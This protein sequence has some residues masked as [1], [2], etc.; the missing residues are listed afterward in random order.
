MKSAAEI[1][2]ELYQKRLEEEAKKKEIEEYWRKY[3][4]KKQKE[5]WEAIRKILGEFLPLGFTIKGTYEL[6]KAVGERKG[7]VARVYVKWHT[8]EFQGSDESPIQQMEGYQIFWE[9][10]RGNHIEN[11]GNTENV[12]DFIEEFGK[13]MADYLD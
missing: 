3:N 1:A 9:F 2:K 13:G 5:Y 7:L 4:E 11:V 8:W 6:Y 12:N 10:L